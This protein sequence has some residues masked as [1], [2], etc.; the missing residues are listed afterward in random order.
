MR[1]G[2]KYTGLGLLAV[3]ILGAATVP[4]WLGAAV[5]HFGAKYG[6]TFSRY[7]RIGYGRFALHDVD[8]RLRTVHVTVSRV[9]ANTPLLYLMKHGDIAGGKWVVEILPRPPGT[10]A[11][12]PSGKPS[13]WVPL[14][15][16]LQRIATQLDQ[17][18]PHVT[19]ESGAVR[20]TGSELTTEGATWTNGA[21]AIRGFAYKTFKLDATL[22]FAAGDVLQFAA[23]GDENA[24][25]LESHGAEV[26]G[27]VTWWRQ[28]AKLDAHFADQG[29]M[30]AA[31]DLQADSWT[32]PGDRLKLGAAYATVRGRAHVTW[33]EGQFLAEVAANGEPVKDKKI[34]PLDVNLRAHGD[35]TVYTIE[36]LHATLPGVVA[37]LTAPVTLDR[38]G[39]FQQSN[40]QFTLVGDLAQLPWFTA[41]GA[42]KGEAH[43][44]SD[45]SAKVPVIAFRLAA[46]HVSSGEWRASLIEAQGQ[47]DWPR[48]TVTAGTLAGTQGESLRWHGGWDFRT[49]EVLDAA[50]EGEVRRATVARWVPEKLQ[51]DHVALKA[52]GAGPLSALKHQGDVQAAGVEWGELHPADVTLHWQGQGAAIET[53]SADAKLGQT[54]V[55]A[56][57]ALA[58]AAVHLNRLTFASGGTERLH[59]TQPAAIHWKPALQIE[60]L[61]LA[62][63]DNAAVDA[64]LTWGQAGS[65]DVRVANFSSAWLDE[66]GVLHGPAWR[67]Q[68]LV[69]NDRWDHGPMSFTVRGTTEI[70][71]GEKRSATVSAALHGDKDGLTVDGL[72]AMEDSRSVVKIN[73]RIP[74][75]LTPGAAQLIGFEPD[76]A[77]ALDATTEPTAAFWAQLT[78][79]TG[80]E[81]REPDAHAHVTGTWAKPQGTVSLK[82]QRVALDPDHFNRSLP[83]L[84]HL[85]IL[86]KGD[87]AGVQLDHLT[88]EIEGQ[89]VS[90][91][92]HL[93][94]KEGAWLDVAK[95]PVAILRH[96]AQGHLEIAD[97]DVSVLARLLPA[98]LAPQGH[99]HVN[100]DYNGGA[101][102]GEL[103]LRDAASRPLGPLGVFQDI[104][105]EIGFAGRK[106]ELRSVTAQSGGQ[107]VKITGSVELPEPPPEK[108]DP[109][110]DEPAAKAKKAFNP[111]FDL[112]LKGDNLPLVRQTGAL[113]RGDL[114]LKLTTDKD[115]H[116]T[117]GGKVRLRNSLFLSDVRSMLPGGARSKS[118]RPPYFAVEIDPYSAW[119]LD[120]AV[121][122]ERFMRLRTTLFSGETSAHFHLGGT[123][124]EPVAIGEITIE[125]GDIKL[126]F[127]TF[128]VQEGHVMLT[129]DQ[130]YDPQVSLIATVKRLNYDL[131]MEVTGKAAAPT[132][133]FSST[134]PL[135]SSQV[136]LLVMAGQ[137]PH[138]EITYTDR[139]RVTQLATFLGQ[140]LLASLTGDSE[141]G[142]NLS[143]VSG[144]Q[145]SQQGKDTYEIEYKLS[146]RWSLT[147][148]YDE[149]DDVNAGVKWRVYSKG[150]HRD[151]DKKKKAAADAAADAAARAKTENE[152]PE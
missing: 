35:A 11:P 151:E 116:T 114:D 26:K 112:S 56:E 77:L 6:L 136:L 24:F 135:E 129:A 134:P 38:T 36:T 130:P 82:A 125:E 60:T 97:A 37:N 141:S 59:L 133:V 86:L 117:I 55:T 34:P 103:K 21:F 42:V 119:K 8:L 51:F 70:S 146:D 111:R 84:D 61:H 50:A 22:T 31:A 62:G 39:K 118:R 140:S 102:S 2:L 147:G 83:P 109:N 57:G 47:F 92:G 96:E 49:H 121:E 53:F 10:P 128:S 127:A 18:A 75:R 43:L 41:T 139:Q 148:E 17:R 16:L 65:A 76:G 122:G 3:L 126:P 13:G 149:F 58:D 79:L 14:R 95:N 74:L 33:H 142:D 67:V 71:L 137:A 81:L 48:V 15:G 30:P 78:A 150:G 25:K 72:N 44:V 80:L 7:E 152:K 54:R 87:S 12:P 4:W 107:T 138:D 85:D 90:A 66:I 20:W 29:W 115:D 19:L 131:R 46:D 52:T 144:E 64:T 132:L 63:P 89:Q 120:V 101:L 91:R 143:I 68:E 88:L 45:I 98:Y 1:R 113:V 9:E 5:G 32:L 100:V 104:N 40:A 123:L 23:Q 28:P 73:G 27:D 124:T 94:V 106:A 145:V 69:A 93:P 108:T 99:L 105:A 110:P